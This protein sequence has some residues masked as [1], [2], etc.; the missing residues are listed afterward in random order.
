MPLFLLLEGDPS[1][2]P[3]LLQRSVLVIFLGKIVY[4]VTEGWRV[5]KMP[6]KAVLF[7]AGYSGH[8]LASFVEEL[9]EREVTVV[10]DVR[11]NPVSRK[12]GS[13]AESMGNKG[14]NWQ[15]QRAFCEA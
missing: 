1:Q 15:F 10:V 6:R 5:T 9:R 2:K 8:N 4:D 11:Q 14:A 12:K 7:T 13:S 3:L